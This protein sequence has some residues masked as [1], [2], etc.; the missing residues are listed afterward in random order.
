MHARR[1]VEADWRVWALAGEDGACSL[2]TFLLDLQT[3]DRDKVLAMLQRVAEHGPRSLPVERCHEVDKT[4]GIFQF[5]AGQ[6]RILWFYEK[7][8]VILCS[9]AFLKRTRKTPRQERER[10]VASRKSCQATG[11]TVLD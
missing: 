5:S 6:V 4:H 10:A 1:V 9:H 2:L 3:R 11:I 8:R 7:G